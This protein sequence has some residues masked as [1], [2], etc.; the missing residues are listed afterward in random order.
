MKEAR[1]RLRVVIERHAHPP[2]LATAEAVRAPDPAEEDE[3]RDE[4]PIRPERFARL[5]TLAGILIDAARARGAS[6]R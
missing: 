2:D 6:S 5:V 1:E 4:S 3:E